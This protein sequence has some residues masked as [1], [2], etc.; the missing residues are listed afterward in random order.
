M[1]Q[2]LNTEMIRQLMT[3]FIPRPANFGV[4]VYRSDNQTHDKTGAWDF[5]EFDTERVDT[6]ITIARPEGMWDD[7]TAAESQRL[8]ATHAGWHV[9]DG[10]INFAASA[11]GVRA[12]GIELNGATFANTLG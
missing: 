4:A 8:Y 10:G 2:W 3:V 9:T 12:I 11:A 7:P 1:P 6:G 5:I